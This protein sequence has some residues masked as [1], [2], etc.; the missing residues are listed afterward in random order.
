MSAGHRAVIEPSK[1][2]PELSLPS[3]PDGRMVPLRLPGRRAPLLVLVHPGGCEACAAFVAGVAAA[4]ESLRD[5]DGYALVIRPDEGGAAGAGVTT[6]ADREGRAAAA[7]AVAPP[8]VVVADQWGEIHLRHE[9]GNAHDFPSIA[10]LVEWLR[11]LAIQCPECQG[12]S[13]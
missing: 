12:E 5:W 1:R 9:A 7:L 4:S 11:F 13:F 8:A 10:E 6:L 2:L 3:L